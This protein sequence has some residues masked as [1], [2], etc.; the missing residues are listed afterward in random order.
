MI[1]ESQLCLVSISSVTYMKLLETFF[2][3]VK[4]QMLADA[5]HSSVSEA[6]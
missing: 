2:N 4:L 6:L 5:Q 1:D 3:D